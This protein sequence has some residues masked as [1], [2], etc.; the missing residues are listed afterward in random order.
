[1][2]ERG[3]VTSWNA[4]SVTFWGLC[5]MMAAVGAMAAFAMAEHMNIANV[6]PFAIAPPLAFMYGYFKTLSLEV[7]LWGVTTSFLL[8]H[9]SFFVAYILLGFFLRY[10]EEM[11]LDERRPQAPFGD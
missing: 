9:M 8:L 1:M 10:L 4:S 11:A 7:V 2:Y 6:I 5:L 3:T